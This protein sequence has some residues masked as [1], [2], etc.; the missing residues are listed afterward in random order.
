[1]VTLGSASGY[2]MVL[3]AR[4]YYPKLWFILHIIY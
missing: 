1:M 3:R 4:V 2:V